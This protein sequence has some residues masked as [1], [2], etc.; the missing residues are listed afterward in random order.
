MRSPAP[1]LL[2]LAA[3]QLACFADGGTDS[4]ATSL[5]ATTTGSTTAGDPSTGDSPTAATQSSAP[6]TDTGTSDTPTTD[7]ATTD[8]PSTGAANNCQVAPECEAGAVEDSELCD[9]CGVL[10]RTCQ[11]DC[12][13][14]PQT[15][16][17]S[18]DS[19]AFWL[20]P[21][22]DIAW[23][24]FPVDPQAP[25]A[26]KETVLASIALA[27]QKQIYVLTASSYHVLSTTN[28]TWIAAGA[29][30]TIFPELSGVELFHATAIASEPP[31]TLV[32]A[33]AGTDAYNYNFIAAQNQFEYKGNV[34]CCGDDWM[35]PNAPPNP[36]AVRDGWSRI[37]DPDG[38]ITGNLQD[39]CGLDMPADLYAY[40]IS[41]GDGFVY[42][43][44][45]GNCFDFYAP[46][47]YAQFGPFGYPGAPANN[48]IGGA[49]WTDGV[50][51]FRGE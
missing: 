16:Q 2:L 19:C 39:L 41:I 48:L 45:I 28:Q 38:W 5:T 29:R 27:P 10:R 21:Q 36:F 11:P 18:L 35:G 25:F 43:Q 1:V 40:T 44:D 42:P 50:Y 24:R 20:L 37:G 6:A 15:C 32:I 47:P 3:S 46:V 7:P 22:G 31:D 17:E 4:A 34:A 13:W 51:I 30:D 49:S 33:V 8:S 14:S 9:S 26:P 23:K 12:T